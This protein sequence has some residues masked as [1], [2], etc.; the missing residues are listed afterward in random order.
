MGNNLNVC[1]RGAHSYTVAEHI[2]TQS[3][4]LFHRSRGVVAAFC[5]SPRFVGRAEIVAVWH[6]MRDVHVCEYA[7]RCV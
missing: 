4:R 6:V 7:S 3:W 1:S 5:R 2:R